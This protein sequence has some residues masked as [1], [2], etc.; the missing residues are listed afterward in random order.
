MEVNCRGK[1]G[2]TALIVAAEAGH[3]GVVQTLLADGR[4][5]INWGA[6]LEETRS[7]LRKYLMEMGSDSLSS[8]LVNPHPDLGR[9]KT[10]MDLVPQL[11]PEFHFVLPILFLQQ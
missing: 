6:T 3:A 1:G 5:E 9:S 7:S 4:V 10:L 11:S 8:A 2:I